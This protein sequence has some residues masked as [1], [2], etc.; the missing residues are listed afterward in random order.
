MEAKQIRTKPEWARQRQPAPPNFG[1]ARRVPRWRFGV[2]AWRRRRKCARIIRNSASYCESE[3]G[4]VSLVI[5]SCKRLPE[6]QRL[7]E[8]LVPFLG[9]IDK[10]ARLEKILVDNG[11]GPE[12]LDYAR[13]LDFF[14]E[15][16]AHSTNL[17]MA[18]ALNDAFGKCRG[19]YILLLEEDFVLEYSE[20]FLQRC[21]G[22]FSEYPEIGIIR[23][24]NQNNWWKPFRRI[25]PLRA[26]SDGTEF[27]TW[28]PS[29][30]GELNVWASGSVLFRKVSFC[31]V[32]PISQGPNVARD[33]KLHQG[34]LYERVYGREYNKV[35]L[36]AKVKDC[37]PFVQPNDNV[38]SPGWGE[39]E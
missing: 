27:W 17:G 15:I 18:A 13:G 38:D 36:A 20:P 26:T 10:A 2:E 33:Q 24:K 8:S 11:S 29:A 4:L 16:V 35:W 37:Y 34:S 12:L 30:D 1:Q 28:L 25:G 19:E 21:A 22:I 5:L 14:D 9:G 39:I 6:L 32:G 31:S 23:L 7:C 3:Q